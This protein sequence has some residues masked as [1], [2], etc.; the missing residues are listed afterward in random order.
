MPEYGIIQEGA[1]TTKYLVDTF[2]PFYIPDLQQARDWM[3][4]NF[5]PGYF[6]FP[7]P[8]IGYLTKDWLDKF[9]VKIEPPDIPLKPIPLPV[10]T[11]PTYQIVTPTPY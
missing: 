10:P 6:W 11:P 3:G 5:S 4:V 9:H 8:S 1:S 7:L 2:N